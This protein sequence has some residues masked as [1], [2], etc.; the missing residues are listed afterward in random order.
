MKSLFKKI[1][2]KFL[3]FFGDIKV[4]KYPFWIIY[5]PCQYQV[6]GKKLREIL[7]AL[8]P[9]DILCRGYVNYLDGYF[10]PGKYSHSGIFVGN[11]TV[12]HA[13]AEGVERCDVLD[14]LKCDCVCI[15]RPK[16]KHSTTLAVDRAHGYLGTNYDFNFTA[17]DEALY[18]H[19][20]TATCYREKKIKKHIPK[21]LWGLIKGKEPLYLAQSFI[22]SDDFTVIGEFE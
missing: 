6:E 9:G 3:T 19:E 4:F 14:F 10:I 2:D 20:L 7:S 17:G 15:V 8:R 21:L 5:D 16:D 11:N 12:I 1:K 13:I 22:E 18:C